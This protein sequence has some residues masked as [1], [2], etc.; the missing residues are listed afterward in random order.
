MDIRQLEYAVEVAKRGSYTKAADAL[1]VSRQGLSKAVKNLE[2]EIGR[3]LFDCLLYTSH[4]GNALPNAAPH[5]GLRVAQIDERLSLHADDGI[6]GSHIACGNGAKQR[7]EL[8]FLH[9]LPFFQPSG[10]RHIMH[11]IARLLGGAVAARPSRSAG[12][13]RPARPYPVS[14]THLENSFASTD[15]R[16]SFRRNSPP[17]TLKSNRLWRLA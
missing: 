8:F 13:R 16:F 14:Y 5:I 1:F 11:T 7:F 2:G 9:A 12:G 4:F 15:S 6:L 3:T 10:C 17:A